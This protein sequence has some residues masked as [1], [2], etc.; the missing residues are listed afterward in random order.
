VAATAFILVSVLVVRSV[1]LVGIPQEKRA[2]SVVSCVLGTRG[3][4]FGFERI[5]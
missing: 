2:A 4:V 5:R 1:E 3:S